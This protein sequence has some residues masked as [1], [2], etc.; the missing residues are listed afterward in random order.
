MP[1][2]T[3]LIWIWLSGGVVVL[4]QITK[5]LIASRLALGQQWQLL[6]IF[7]LTLLHNRGAAF[8]FLGSVG[9]WGG[10]LFTAFAVCISIY[11]IIW[12][13]RLSRK[14]SWLGI[15]LALIL[16]GAMG[17]LWDRLREGYVTDFIQFHYHDWYFAAFNVADSAI[18][19]GAFMIGMKL[20]FDKV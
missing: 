5:A 13:K 8:S 17:N 9:P 10:W 12:M 19:V 6:P 7:N 2:K 20:I 11:L 3:A 4:D 16:G 14:K 15:A 1:K 18:C